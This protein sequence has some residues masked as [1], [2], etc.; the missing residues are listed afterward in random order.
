MGADHLKTPLAT[1]VGRILSIRDS[2]AGQSSRRIAVAGLS[3]TFA[4]GCRTG[5]RV[6]RAACFAE[7]KRGLVRRVV[8]LRPPGIHVLVSTPPRDRTFRRPPLR[9]GDVI[10]ATL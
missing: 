1:T 3:P 7:S 10:V 5:V 6:D 9:P 4:R 8:G 2:D